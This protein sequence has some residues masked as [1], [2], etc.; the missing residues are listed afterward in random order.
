MYL[1]EAQWP[2]PQIVLQLENRVV[3][4]LMHAMKMLRLFETML[5]M[6]KVVVLGILGMKCLH[7]KLF[8]M[9]FTKIG[10]SSLQSNP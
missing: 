8:P 2:V 7:V 6:V 9:F 5:A 10:V 3:Q 1:A 4:G